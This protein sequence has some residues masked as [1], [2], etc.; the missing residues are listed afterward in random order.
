MDHFEIIP[1]VCLCLLKFPRVVLS[2]IMERGQQTF[3]IPG[4]GRGGGVQGGGEGGGDNG[5]GEAWGRA[6][7]WDAVPTARDF[8]LL[9]TWMS[10]GP[11]AVPEEL[12][13]LVQE[14]VR[15]RQDGGAARRG[16]F[17]SGYV[18]R[19]KTLTRSKAA[20]PAAGGGLGAGGGGGGGG[21]ATGS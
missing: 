11:G 20:E 12:R 5:G 10:G 15:V 21:A 17:V 16:A 18:A 14:A 3:S 2:N 13:T 9:A 8:A 19:A 1:L 7:A 6:V 4:F